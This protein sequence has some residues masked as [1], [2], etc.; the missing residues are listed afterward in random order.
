MEEQAVLYSVRLNE[1]TGLPAQFRFQNL[2]FD[3]V[4]QQKEH[5]LTFAEQAV[6]SALTVR[7]K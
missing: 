1:S 7:K 5:S 4:K 2:Y 6:L 3:N